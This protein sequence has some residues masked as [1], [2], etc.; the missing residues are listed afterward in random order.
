M[1]DPAALCLRCT[2]M[3]RGWRQ[4]VAPPSGVLFVVWVVFFFFFFFFLTN[5]GVMMRLVFSPSERIKGKKKMWDRLVS[6]TADR[7]NR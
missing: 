3:T 5:L 6:D 7:I 1:G 4:R 2:Q